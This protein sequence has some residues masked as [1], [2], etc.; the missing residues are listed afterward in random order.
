MFAKK[1]SQGFCAF[2]V[3]IFWGNL[4]EVQFTSVSYS[5]ICLNFMKV[6][7]SKQARTIIYVW[8][9]FCFSNLFLFSMFQ[10]LPFFM[11]FYNYCNQK[12][13]K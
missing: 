12:T 5:Y 7:I 8:P 9:E 13:S 11:L 10:F 6:C 2:V 1:N 3:F 4:K